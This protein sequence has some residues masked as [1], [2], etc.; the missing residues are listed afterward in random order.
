MHWI[1]FEVS[2]PGLV[3]INIQQTL[4]RSLL[5]GHGNLVAILVTIVP[6]LILLFLDCLCQVHSTSSLLD[7]GIH[8]A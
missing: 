2:S 4:L 1:A 6:N 8:I 3:A 5:L 7:A